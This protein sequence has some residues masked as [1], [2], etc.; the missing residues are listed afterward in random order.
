[1]IL[2]IAPTVFLPKLFQGLGNIK[3]EYEIKLNKMLSHAMPC[4]WL[5]E[6]QFH[7]GQTR[8]K[9]MEATGVISKVDQPTN[10]CAGMVVVQKK[11]GGVSICVDLKPL[12]QTVLREV[13]P[14]THVKETLAQLQGG[15]VFSKLDANS[16]FWQVP[17]TKNSRYLTTF[18]AS[19]GCYCFNKLPFGISI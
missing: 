13:H 7:I 16:G 10:W 5:F 15:K 19:F 9:Q 6:Y 12:S 4:S 14:I 11:S 3:A 2:K 18:I 1:M 17:L 8:A